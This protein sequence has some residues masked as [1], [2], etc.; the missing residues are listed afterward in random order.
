VDAES[1]PYGVTEIVPE[2]EGRIRPKADVPLLAEAGL[3]SLEPDGSELPATL[4]IGSTPA[5][6]V[7][8]PLV[9][10]EGVEK[11]PLLETVRYRLR[12]I[13]LTTI[14]SSLRVYDSFPVR[15]RVPVAA[16]L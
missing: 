16:S 7:G 15:R 6:G 14:S 11:I 13:R 4:R 10:I 2:A 3:V 12:F 1:L 5:L 9:P 8:F